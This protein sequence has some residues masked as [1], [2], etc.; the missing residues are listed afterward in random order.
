[1]A[2][3]LVMAAPFIGE[4]RRAIL[5]RF[6]GHF[7]LIVGGT[8]AIAVGAAVLAALARI[9]D[10]RPWRYAAIGLALGLA[11]GYAFVTRTGDPQ[12]DAVERFHF[13][14]Y[15]VITLL[16]Y[17]AWRPAADL[18]VPALTVL[19]G[20]LVGT[21]EEWFQ[22]FIPGRVGEVRDVFLN[23]AA[24]A[25]GLIFSVALDPPA[26]ST[27]GL[28]PASLRR[29][30]MFGA[31]VV[32]VFAAFFQCVHLGFLVT[33]RH[34]RFRSAYTGA[35]LDAL[36]ADRANRW[37]GRSVERPARLS[38]EDQYMTEGHWHVAHRNDAWAVSDIATAW[39]ENLILERYFAPVL[40]TPSYLSLTGHRWG[41]GHRADAERQFGAAP[42]PD[43]YE[44]AAQ[45]SAI[46]VWPQP[47]YW[48]IVMV[49][50][51]LLAAPWIVS[52]LRRSAPS[53]RT[54][55]VSA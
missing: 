21:L 55:P 11:G 26:G 8:V 2:V 40:D 48:T 30:G 46:H 45:P 54:P 29:I 4:I 50:A 51:G 44:S 39:H 13:V 37:R 24:I 3:A 1:V 49:L 6:P 16:F 10:R 43:M 5:G 47:V 53:E 20:L 32:L 17:R 33:E 38:A 27:R 23:G 15:G 9:R 19:S 52:R 14:E 22:W 31:V 12:V 41:T 25:A 34:W 35:E 18:S 42:P 7:V 36:S 28:K